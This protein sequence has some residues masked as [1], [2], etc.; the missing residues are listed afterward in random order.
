MARQIEQTGKTISEAVEAAVKKLGVELSDIEY[1][2]LSEG[3]KG[4]LGLVLNRL[5]YLLLLLVKMRQRKFL[6]K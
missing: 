1:K 4:F 6:K 3:S 5:R 2:V